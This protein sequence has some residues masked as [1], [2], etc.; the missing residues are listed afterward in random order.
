MAQEQPLSHAVLIAL[1]RIVRAID[2]HSK[3]LVQQHGVTG[4]QMLVLSLLDDA[5]I[6]VGDIARAANLSQATVTDILDRLERRALVQRTRSA[7]DK[8]RVLV[9]ATPAARR[10]LDAS[11]SLLQDSFMQEFAK[12]PDWEQTNIVATLQRVAAMMNAQTLDAAPMLLGDPL[13]EIEDLSTAD[14]T[15]D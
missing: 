15:H 7:A 10:I 3:K 14:S 13:E 4:P 9:S 5:G 2:L 6:S 12:L 11:P 8:R 1:R